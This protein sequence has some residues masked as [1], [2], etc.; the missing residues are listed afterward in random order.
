MFINCYA[1]GQ[2]GHLR[3]GCP[4]ARRF[5]PALPAPS[6]ERRAPETWTP[7]RVP[8]IITRKGVPPSAE[9]LSAREALFGAA[10]L[11]R[12][13]FRQ[14]YRI[15]VRTG[16]QLGKIAARQVSEAREDWLSG[17]RPVP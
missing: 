4:S 7:P 6:R 17:L 8:E 10:P 12:T 3:S 5:P 9:Y 2:P 11:V 1:C 14:E 15:P 16:E 13:R